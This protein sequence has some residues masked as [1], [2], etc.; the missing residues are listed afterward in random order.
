MMAANDVGDV[1]E[2]VMHLLSPDEPLGVVALECGQ[3]C[4]ISTE[5]PY[6]L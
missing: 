4:L 3:V 5:L 6:T 1:K 2:S